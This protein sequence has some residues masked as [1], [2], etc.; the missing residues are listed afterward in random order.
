MINVLI[1]SRLS[2][3]E[4]LLDTIMKK[5]R[6]FPFRLR[7]NETFDYLKGNGANNLNGNNYEFIPLPFE[8]LFIFL[9]SS[10]MAALHRL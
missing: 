10:T 2:S 6:F 3:V 9:L 4:D 1:A 8:A 7:K 5:T